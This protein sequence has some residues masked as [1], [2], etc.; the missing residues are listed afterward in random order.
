MNERDSVQLKKRKYDFELELELFAV[1][2]VACK[3][4]VLGQIA[5]FGPSLNAIPYPS[6]KLYYCAPEPDNQ[7]DSAFRLHVHT[8]I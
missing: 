2:T 7:P 8:R 4:P 6:E 3:V 1:P 5:R